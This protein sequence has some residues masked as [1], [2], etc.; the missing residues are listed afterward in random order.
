MNSATQVFS[1][2]VSAEQVFAEAAQHDSNVMI[3][4]EMATQFINIYHKTAHI[5]SEELAYLLKSYVEEFYEGCMMNLPLF[6]QIRSM[7]E[8]DAFPF[9]HTVYDAIF[10]LMWPNYCLDENIN[11]CK[12]CCNIDLQSINYLNTAN[13]NYHALHKIFTA[14]YPNIPTR[15]EDLDDA[16]LEPNECSICLY[17]NT[18]KPAESANLKLFYYST[19]FGLNTAVCQ[20]C[21]LTISAKEEVDPDYKPF[22]FRPVNRVDTV[23]NSEESAA[24]NEESAAHNEESAAHNEESVDDYEESVDNYKTG[25][26]A[27]W[28]AAMKY[29]E[30]QVKEYS[31]IPK[32]DYCGTVGKTKKCGGSCNG[33]VRYCS[34]EC[35]TADW[36]DV[37]KYACLKN[38]F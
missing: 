8:V 19:A 23:E 21:L 34:K 30:G 11:Y 35:Q 33:K 1:E 16:T 31:D 36:R 9:V 10:T 2:Q 24:H 38:T 26:R 13:A 6:K 3:T 29:I 12:D 17:D 22:E 20:D 7:T 4:R 37:H 5:H 27:G 18:T 14:H 32:C 25:W 28:K 15:D